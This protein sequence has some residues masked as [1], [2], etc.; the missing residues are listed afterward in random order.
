L[1]EDLFQNQTFGPLSCTDKKTYMIRTVLFLLIVLFSSNDLI[2]Q[3]D[4]RVKKEKKTKEESLEKDTAPTLKTFNVSIYITHYYPYCGGAYPD[5]SQQNNYQ[6][7][8]NTNFVLINFT[9]NTET[10]VQ[11]DSTGTLK[12]N[13]APGKYGIKEMFKNIPF[14]EFYEK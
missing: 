6:P 14:E 13:L 2:A 10:I 4:K 3:K 8:R 9:A 7:L 5:E 12:L 11:S 1:P